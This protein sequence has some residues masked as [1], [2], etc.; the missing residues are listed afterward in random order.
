MTERTL[1]IVRRNLGISQPLTCS[2]PSTP[3]K[4]PSPLLPR[5]STLADQIQ[6]LEWIDPSAVRAIET[7]VAA[8]YAKHLRA[9]PKKLSDTWG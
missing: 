5:P 2:T 6:M 7:F 1:R 3:P 4:P 8:E 9:A